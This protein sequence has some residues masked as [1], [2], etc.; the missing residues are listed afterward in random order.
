MLGVKLDLV[1]ADNANL[2]D[3]EDDAIGQ[4]VGLGL[5]LWPSKILQTNL[6][7]EFGSSFLCIEVS[8]AYELLCGACLTYKTV[9]NVFAEK[10]ADCSCFFWNPLA[11][12]TLHM[13]D[14]RRMNMS[15]R[16]QMVIV[17]H[18]RNLQGIDIVVL[19]LWALFVVG[20]VR[21]RSI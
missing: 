12:S 20:I 8:L 11:K 14:D 10:L 1:D 6:T 18:V 16:E 17:C 5:G 15:D 2:V 4:S 19:I 3:V 7:K 21:S 9:A 13:L